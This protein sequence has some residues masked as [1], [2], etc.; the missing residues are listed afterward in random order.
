MICSREG[1]FLLPRETMCEKASISY[2]FEKPARILMAE[3]IPDKEVC[4][5][6][7]KTS[8]LA[9]AGIY[10]ILKYVLNQLL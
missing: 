5:A 6:M 10:E 3:N 7:Q 8:S 4:E 2:K 1:F 9:S